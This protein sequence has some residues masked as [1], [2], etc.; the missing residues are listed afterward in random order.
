MLFTRPKYIDWFLE[1][2]DSE[3][4][5]ESGETVSVFRIA[6]LDDDEK[7]NEWAKHILRHY[8]SDAQ[9]KS[10][11]DANC[12]GNK[13]KYISD[14]IIKPIEKKDVSGD[15]GEIIFC[16]FLEYVLDYE[17]PRYKKL[18]TLPSNPTQGIDLFGFKLKTTGSNEVV[19]MEVKSRLA[20]KK[21]NAV[22]T[23]IAESINREDTHRAFLL[24]N[25]RLHYE[26]ASDMDMTGK[27]TLLQS[28]D[29]PPLRRTMAGIITTADECDTN[30]FIGVKIETGKTC[31][32]FAL[33]G[34]ELW[35]LAQSLYE[36]ACL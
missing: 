36:R 23:S 20:S 10:G 27:I 5:I 17:V 6:H 11:A 26:F 9:I 22:G 21:F 7:L 25:A 19:F 1:K 30:D 14:F 28:S 8:R 34:L 15:F 2:T 32:I 4:K 24:E 13:S 12:G 3:V 35:K 29:K 33:H 18:N 31:K 16:D